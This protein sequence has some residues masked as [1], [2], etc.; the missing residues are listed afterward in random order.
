MFYGI[1]CIGNGSLT[2]ATCTNNR[3]F[4]TFIQGKGFSIMDLI[5]TVC[6]HVHMHGG[7][8]KLNKGIICSYLP[9]FWR[10]VI[11]FTS[12]KL[13]MRQHGMVSW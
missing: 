7:N 2:N 8:R 12:Q 9:T 10:S 5:D 1:C 11:N 4:V 13:H 6:V 3:G